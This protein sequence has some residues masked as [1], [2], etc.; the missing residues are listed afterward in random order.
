[1]LWLNGTSVGGPL[2]PLARAALLRHCYLGSPAPAAGAPGGALNGHGANR[3]NA[4]GNSGS[5]R[6]FWGDVGVFAHCPALARLS[7]AHCGL[8]VRGSFAPVARACVGL[9][10]LELHGTG[11]VVDLA[12]CFGRRLP[13]S[14]SYSRRQIGT[15]GSGGN[16]SSGG[17]SSSSSC[18]RRLR[19]LSLAGALV[20]GDVRAGLSGCFRLEDLRLQDTQCTGDLAAAL[21]DMAA[22]QSR[23]M[24]RRTRASAKASAASAVSRRGQSSS[25]CG[26]S[27]GI[28]APSGDARCRLTWLNVVGS[29]EVQASKAALRRAAAEECAIFGAS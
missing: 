21:A 17:S 25:D 14:D 3:H 23:A 15:S 6:G 11:V 7:L 24:P 20:C 9:E 8:R 1:V 29:S 19:R 16:G 12:A 26:R 18:G 22:A 4:K 28:S 2:R 5:V 27:S 13:A 10:E